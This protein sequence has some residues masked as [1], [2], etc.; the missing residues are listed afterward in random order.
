MVIC[1]PYW[2]EKAL[3]FEAWGPS[4]CINTAPI[5]ETATQSNCLGVFS[6]FYCQGLLQPYSLVDLVR[7]FLWL[8]AHGTACINERSGQRSTN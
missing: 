5:D 8:T 4:V 6:Y 2:G 7:T 1:A 3:Y